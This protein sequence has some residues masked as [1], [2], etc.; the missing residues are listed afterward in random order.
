MPLLNFSGVLWLVPILK[1]GGAEFPAHR[2]VS[3][4]LE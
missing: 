1:E 4:T 2:K 3:S